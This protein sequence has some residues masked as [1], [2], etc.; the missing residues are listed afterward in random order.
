MF[1][2]LGLRARSRKFRAFTL[3]ELLVVITIIGI[4]IA[5]LLPA[6]QA[7]REAA[8]GLQ[9]A[10]NLKQIGLA[11]HSYAS[12]HGV[13]PPGAQSVN[14]MSF[15]VMILPQMEQQALFDLFNFNKGSRTDPG[16]LENALHPIPGFLCPSCSELRSNQFA[17]L[18]TAADRWPTTANGIDAYTTHYV[19]IM[20]PIG[21]SYNV[22][23]RGSPYQRS[24]HG[25]LMRDCTVSLDSVTDGTSCTFAVGE[26]SW[27]GYERYRSWMRGST[28]SGDMS[29]CKNVYDP[30]GARIPYGNTN[31]GYNDGSFSSE[32]QGGSYFMMCDGSAHFISENIDYQLFLALASRNGNET[33]Q[34]P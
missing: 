12:S 31:Y 11:L 27:V 30:I 19:G 17:V 33:A 9:C 18:G 14:D 23:D 34:V 2:T 10:N 6:V 32:H 21:D 24:Q 22:T 1:R 29:N 15:F 8:R 7:A 28:T 25:V 16:K 3:V 4:L 20:G 5:L 26:I 13:L